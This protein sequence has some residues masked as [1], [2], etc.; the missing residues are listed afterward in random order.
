M[1]R[2][3][4]MAML[5]G[6]MAGIAEVGAQ[7]AAFAFRGSAIHVDQ[8][9]HWRHWVYQNPRVS[10]LATRMDSTQ[11]F[12]FTAAGAKPRYFTA[13]KN[14]ATDAGEYSY[15]VPLPGYDEVRHGGLSALSNARLAALAGDGDPSTFWE[16]AS[17]DFHREGLPRWQVRIDLG[18]AVWADSIVVICPEDGDVPKRFAVEVSMGKQSGGSSSRNYQYHLIR[19][20]E[21]AEGVRRFV[22]PLDPHQTEPGRADFDQ[23]GLPDMPGTFV[24]FVRLSI[25]D[26]DLAEGEL[27]GEGEAGRLRYESLPSGHRGRTVY[28]RVTMGGLVKRIEDRARADGSVITAAQTHGAL[29]DDERGPTLC[30]RRELPRIAEIQVWGHGP[31]LAYRPETRSG[32]SFEDG[33]L[34]SPW[35]ATDGVYLTRWTGN[36]WDAEYSTGGGSQNQLV[37]CTMWL[38]LGATFWVDETYVGSVTTAETG[39]EGSLYGLDLLGSDGTVAGPLNMQTPADFT[40]LEFGLQW[41]DLTSDSHKNN[42][43]NRNRIIGERF[44]QR[45]LRFFQLRNVDPTGRMSGAYSAPGNFNEFQVY[46]EGYPAE[47]S[48]TSP[49]IILIPGA[50]MEEAAAQERRRLPGWIQWDTRAAVHRVMADTGDESESLE[51]LEDNPEVQVRIQTRTSE[52]IDSLCT[53]YSITGMGTTSER[54]VQIDAG[55]F[56]E[57]KAVWDVYEAWASMPE[58]RT[59]QL[60]SHQTDRDDD[61]DGLT[62]EDGPGDP[63]GHGVDD[64]GDGLID[65]DGL[66]GAVGGPNSRGTIVLLKH[67]RRSDDDGDGRED[68]DGIDGIDNDGDFLVDEDGRKKAK[69]R[70]GYDRVVTPR[71]GHW[72]P[73]S[74]P[75][76]A[77]SGDTRAQITSP[78]P[79]KFLQ[80]RISLVSDDPHKT[81]V[82]RSL[83]ASFSDAAEQTR[84]VASADFD[85]DGRVGYMDLFAFLRSYGAEATG[86]AARYDLDGDG[87]VGLDDFFAFA[88]A[89]GQQTGK[90]LAGAALPRVPGGLSLQANAV[91]DTLSL[92]VRAHGLALHGYAARLE[93]DASA[94]RLEGIV[95][96]DSEVEPVL[97]HRDSGGQ[98]LLAGLVREGMAGNL[99]HLQFSRLK[100]S[101]DGSFRLLEAVVQTPSGDLARPERLGSAVVGATPQA[102]SLEPNYPNPFNPV[103][104]IRYL[105]PEDCLVRLEV[106]DLLGRRV[107]LLVNE[108]RAASLHQ[109]HW[110]GRDERGALVGAGVY[111][112]QLRAGDVVQV[113][114]MLLLK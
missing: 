85:G 57:L 84:A 43:T 90:R 9:S 24:H 67:A 65:E 64:D 95:S 91:G 12:E 20:G 10:S 86:A 69:P 51:P 37:C 38:D 42:W 98:I 2:P 61:G 107:R 87:M 18:R 79:A 23:D 21:A 96:P 25:L 36:A 5:I 11:L 7:D 44:S 88:M 113:R 46:G 63:A 19:R 39:V 17:G 27:L 106:I 50:T 82:V 81:A 89:F 59:L 31:N 104:T 47:V 40:Q 70:Q 15:R 101:A 60:L 30:F 41:R 94:Y 77:V 68:E 35:L 99:A 1:R 58:S 102:P 105:L 33:G 3:V 71:F 103:T 55:E 4:L 93:Y 54:R 22:F 66:T 92:E 97:L 49:P 34:G 108:R 100:G 52:R 56:A 114:K 112:C 83:T 110:D 8:T 80:I 48:F 78:G 6:V 62:D 74:T 73:W 72:S 32:G 13:L 53:Y 28:Q 75:Y 14:Y 16:P 109:A 26:S 76:R 29:P 45:K 111:L